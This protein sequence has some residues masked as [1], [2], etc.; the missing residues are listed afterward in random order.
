MV[1]LLARCAAHWLGPFLS[2]TPRHRS[3]FH[4]FEPL[5]RKDPAL[6]ASL[7]WTAQRSGLNIPPERMFWIHA[8][9]KTTTFEAYVTGFGASKRI[10][11]F[12]TAIAKATTPEIVFVAAHEMGHY[13]LG[14]IPKFLAFGAV[15]LFV[16]FYLGFRTI[17]WV[18]ARWR[19][20]WEV[21]GLD[22]W[23]SLLHC[24]FFFRFLASSP[25]PSSTPTA[26]ILNTKRTSMAWRS[27]TGSRLTPARWWLKHFA[28][29]VT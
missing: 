19:A 6:V 7:E 1:L 12:D 11:V 27:L 5:Q 2:S 16:L 29:T 21:R 25:R 9:E 8:S 14:H 26:G 3:L 24:S 15:F 4:K 22:D 20:K 23:A 10:V 18:L 13:V 28:F 17:G